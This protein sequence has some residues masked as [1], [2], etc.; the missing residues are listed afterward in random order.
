MDT[1]HLIGD[2]DLVK[3][4]PYAPPDGGWGWVVMIASFICNLVLDGIAYTF[5]IFLIP[6]MEH[7]GVQKGPM[8]LV[9]S[10]L[11]GTIQL[12]G[13]FVA[14]LVNKFG[15][16]VVCIAG[17]VISA[18]G[19]F[20]STFATSVP[21]LMLLYSIVAGTGLGLMYVPAVVAVGYYFEK[22]RAFA[23][24]ISVCGSGA[25]TFILA[26]LAS[27]MLSYYGW[28][29]A[30]R[31]LAGLCLQCAVC[32]AVMRPLPRRKEKVEEEE[33]KGEPA[34][35]FQSVVSSV[36]DRRL[37]T[38]IPFLLLLLANLFSTMGLYIPYMYLP[39][40]AESKGIPAVDA[41][42]LISV[43]GICNTLGR[44]LSGLLT[45][46]PCV[47]PM[48]VTT[49][50]LTFGG[51]CP[52]L[53]ALC[54]EYWSFLIIS[55][56]FGTFLSAWVAVTS[57]VLVELLGLELLTS[58]FGTLTFVRGCAALLGPPLA[59]FIVD[60]TGDLDIAFYISSG[61]LVVSAVVSLASYL[62][63]KRSQ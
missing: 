47:D 29:G 61:L 49:L 6:L 44:I 27:L 39:S 37:L 53:M 19:F 3:Y 28:E 54:V 63:I 41:S 45:D 26:P 58:A 15:T 11:A 8:S 35:C 24:G 60:G 1:E 46:I 59:G 13:P 42:F 62:T 30:T 21:V 36:F 25:G 14:V 16:R 18:T 33:E 31:I 2:V 34:P 22:K 38:N 7:F 40:Q 50:A 56:L 10:V 5:G 9:G 55:V 43:V 51:L 4:D 20:A 32:G 52:L 48:V 12:V 17:A 57:P 23:T